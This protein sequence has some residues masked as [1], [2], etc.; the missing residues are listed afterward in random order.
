MVIY[1]AGLPLPQL[2]QTIK[3]NERSI[4][5]PMSNGA[6]RS[7]T[8]STGVSTEYQL[9]F[10]YNQVEY[11][12]FTSWIN[13]SLKGIDAWFECSMMRDDGVK[14]ENVRFTQEYSEQKTSGGQWLVSAVVELKRKPRIDEQTALER[15][16]GS[17]VLSSV[18]AT[19]KNS[20]QKYTV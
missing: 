1:P 15:L 7:R 6:R 19:L 4:R 17:Q 12:A 16:Y 20:L 13:Y 2:Q 11:D 3:N 14:K 18:L 8:I 5:S 9:N 10:I